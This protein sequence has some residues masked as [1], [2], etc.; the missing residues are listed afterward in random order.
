MIAMTVIE[1][2]VKPLQKKAYENKTVHKSG[3]RRSTGEPAEEF[4]FVHTV[5]ESLAAIDKHD[6]N[7]IVELTAK[8]CIGVDI[9]FL[10][11]EAAPAR[12]FIQAFFHYFAQMTPFAGVDDDGSG[13]WHAG[14]ILTR[15]NRGFPAT[16]AGQ[17]VRPP[18]VE[19]LRNQ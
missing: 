5:F 6:R 2:P 10:P 8:F 18:F 1:S 13:I 11:R 3:M 7:F 12:Q 16:N 4:L 17:V 15:R 9:D 19:R 14:W